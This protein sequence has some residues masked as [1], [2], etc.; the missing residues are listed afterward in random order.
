[1][2][3]PNYPSIAKFQQLVELKDYRPPTRKEYVRYVR[4][5][6]EHCQCDPATL[7]ENQVR[8]YFL[9]LRQHKHYTR[10]PMK[11]AKFALRC[12][13]QECLQV[14][15]WTVF[16]EV[17]IAEP[18]VLPIVLSRAEVAAVLAAVR[19][20]RFRACLRLMYHCGL[21]VGETVAIE[22]QDLHGRETPPRLHVRNGKGGSPRGRTRRGRAQSGWPALPRG[23]DRFVPLAA[24][25][26]A[27]LRRWWQT[28]RHPRL[29]FPSPGR[30]WADRTLSLSEVMHQSPAPMSVSSVQMAFRLARAASGVNPAATTHSLRHSY[31]THLLE[32][33]VSLRQISQYLGHES[34]DTTVIYTHLTALSEARTQAAL[35]AL[36]QPLQP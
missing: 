1:M 20:P 10:S 7:T 29:L 22:V 15:G 9:F 3:I 34:L 27:E 5:L 25:L 16:H 12:F 32:E 31:A 11:A 23:K 36:Y 4:K 8:E 21:R 30:G 33:G 6:A 17:R 19:E 28:H 13:F 18:Q 14:Q 2:F 35:A 26:I 24:P